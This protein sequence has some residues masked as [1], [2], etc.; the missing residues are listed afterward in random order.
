VGRNTFRQ[1]FAKVAMD[2]NIHFMDAPPSPAVSERLL[3]EAR[4]ALYQRGFDITTQ[5]GSGG[6]AKCFKVRSRQY[7]EDFVV[8][9]FHL[10]K[11][12]ISES[13]TAEISAL[14]NLSH[15]NVIQLFD[16]F[17]SES[18]LYLILE[19]CP[20]GSMKQLISQCGAIRPPRLYMFCSQI[21]AAL[22]YCHGKDISHCDIKPAN[23]FV[24]K[25]GR[26]KLA[27]FGL[28]QCHHDS[29]LIDNFA[30]SVCYMAPEILKREP[31]DPIKADI[32]SLGISF[33]E[34][35]TGQVPWN[36]DCTPFDTSQTQVEVPWIQSVSPEFNQI[37]RKLLRIAPEERCGCSEIEFLSIFKRLTSVVR[38]HSAKNMPSEV[39]NQHQQV[40]RALF[41]RQSSAIANCPGAVAAR[42]KSGNR[43]SIGQLL[44]YR[45]PTFLVA[46]DDDIPSYDD[47]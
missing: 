11:D 14:K 39:G 10:I 25:Y 43:V 28:A 5:I 21:V 16:Y 27:D 2:L 38:R 31:H 7:Q 42:G 36:L 35:A 26:A 12:G 13:F 3:G 15:P 44:K 4:K 1:D 41:G 6:F 46:P 19:Y 37:L 20:D 18:L 17:V 33:Y 32:W 45:V 24:D 23:I 40:A 29:P 34:M 22:A 8:K 30:G 9:V 47:A